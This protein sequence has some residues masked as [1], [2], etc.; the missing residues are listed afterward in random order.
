MGVMF[1][2]VRR[3]LPEQDRIVYPERRRYRLQFILRDAR[4][5]SIMF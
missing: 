1:E 4:D 3:R 2:L 5:L